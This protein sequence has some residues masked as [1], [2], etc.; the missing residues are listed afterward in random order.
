MSLGASTLLN[1]VTVGGAGTA[2]NLSA[3]SEWMG[4]GVSV[5]V[6]GISGDTVLLEGS[7]DGST[8]Y[9][10]N[11]FTANG[12]WSGAGG[13][14]HIRGN[15]SVYSAGT[16]T[17]KMNYGKLDANVL[18]RLSAARATLLDNL[19]RLDVTVSSVSS[20][21]A[22]STQAI[23]KQLRKDNINFAG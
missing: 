18:T 21:T 11:S 22:N 13:W 19:S 7:I 3:V 6:T 8:F 9:T 2:I 12:M 23:V 10:I 20:S 4:G 14:T 17:M 15:V 5:E 16:I 1:A